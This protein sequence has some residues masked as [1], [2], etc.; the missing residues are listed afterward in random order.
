MPETS[1]VI[2][3]ARNP[4]GYALHGSTSVPT[5]AASHGCVRVTVP[6]MNR[7]WPRLFIG[8]RVYVYR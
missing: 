8:E 3:S 2:I 5:Y 6:A 4:S 1:A 7:V